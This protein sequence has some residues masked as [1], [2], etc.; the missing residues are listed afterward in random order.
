M[1]DE[2]TMSIA[3]IVVIV[4]MGSMYAMGLFRGAMRNGFILGLT[5]GLVFYVVEAFN[6]FRFYW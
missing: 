4:V 6:Y 2:Q 3:A 5:G 1:L